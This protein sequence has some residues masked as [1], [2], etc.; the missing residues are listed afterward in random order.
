[1]ITPLDIQNKEF[2]RSV[3][4]YDVKEVDIFLD[5]IILDYEKIYKDNIDLRDKTNALSEQIRHF[6]TM[7]ETL[8][9]TL[10]LAQNTSEE[11]INSAKVKAENIISDS[12]ISKRKIIDSAMNDVANIN[13]EFEYLKRE[14]YS[15]KIKYESFINAQLMS[16]DKFFEEIEMVELKSDLPDKSDD[17]LEDMSIEED[18]K[19]FVSLDKK[20]EEFNSL[21]EEIEEKTE[22]SFD[23]S[24]KIDEED[25]FDYLEKVNQKENSAYLDE[26]REE[27]KIGNS[28]EEE[29]N[30]ENTSND[31]FNKEIIDI[32]IREIEQNNLQVEKDIW[33]EEEDSG[34]SNLDDIF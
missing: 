29:N 25:I 2:K 15:F 16:I 7:E 5:E 34:G 26:E 17:A 12:E 13:N 19:S 4:G 8:K 22:E 3:R 28:Q 6:N 27:N 21:N 33:G 10:L 14:M 23:Y 11:L 32:K 1:M 24:E 30:G 9:N 18:E 20:E 31:I